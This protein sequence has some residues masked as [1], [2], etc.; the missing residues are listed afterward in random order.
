MKVI[1]IAIFFGEGSLILAQNIPDKNPPSLQNKKTDQRTE[2]KKDIG[3]FTYP[4]TSR[5]IFYFTKGRDIN[6]LQTLKL[7]PD[8]SSVLGVVESHRL[9]LWGMWSVVAIFFKERK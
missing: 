4:C 3:L 2:L 8:D 6:T 7:D 1:A 5:E 9:F